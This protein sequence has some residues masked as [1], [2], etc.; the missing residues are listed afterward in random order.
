MVELPFDPYD[1]PPAPSHRRE[2]L[3]ANS[4]QDDP[5]A[6]MRRQL[7]ASFFGWVFY[8]FGVMLLLGMSIHA[9]THIGDSDTFV[10]GLFFF[11]GWIGALLQYRFPVGGPRGALS[12][13]EKWQ[14]ALGT[15]YKIGKIL[16]GAGVVIGTAAVVL[17]TVL[18]H[19]VGDGGTVGTIVLVVGQALAGGCIFIGRRLM[20][21]A[22][23]D[24]A[25]VQA[26]QNP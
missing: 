18:E 8:S 10:I 26:A 1:S 23:R 9:L 5:L 13:A 4:S 16:L 2:P 7:Q 12:R 25:A 20:S 15:N 11:C 24:A 14:A 22:E 21:K 19:Q 3:P 6:I 17:C